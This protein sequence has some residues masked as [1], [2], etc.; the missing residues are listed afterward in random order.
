[1]KL[2]FYNPISRTLDWD[3]DSGSYFKEEV[4]ESD[5]KELTATF[6]LLLLVTVTEDRG[7]YLNPPTLNMY[8]E[9]VE[10]YSLR[11]WNDEG[12]V[13]LTTELNKELEKTI[14]DCIVWD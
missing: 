11:L 4:V 10:V 6:N 1:M 9:V 12:E 5:D 14:L 7:D 8:E 3:G 2:N 13:E